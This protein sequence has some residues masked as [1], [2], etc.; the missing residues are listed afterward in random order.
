MRS[1]VIFQPYANLILSGVK[2]VEN[3]RWSTPYRGP[4]AIHSG[5]SRKWL[6]LSEDG[7]EDAE[8]GLLISAMVFGAVVG[9]CDLV[10]CVH[11]DR[12]R[13]CERALVERFPWITT[14]EHAEGHYC[15]IL[16]NVRRL[17]KPI[18]C[19]GGQGF[20]HVSDELLKEFTCQ[21]T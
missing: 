5:K 13:L 2:R 7:T 10:E 19:R 17:A 3:R 6:E 4:L 8:Y 12:I 15:F 9:V 14:H 1:L 16:D 11:I 18:Y 20:F 21:K